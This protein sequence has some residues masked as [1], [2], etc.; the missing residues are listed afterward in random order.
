MMTKGI[1]H[2]RELYKA[3]TVH[4]VMSELLDTIEAENEKY[5][6]FITIDREKVLRRAKELDKKS[7]DR[8]ELFG[9]P[10]AVKDNIAVKDMRLTCASRILD[11]YVS[12]YSA[13]VV[14]RML[15]E[16]AIIIGKTNLDEFA[17]GSSTEYSAFSP[18]RNP[19]APDYVPGGSSGGSAAAVAAGLAPLALGSDTGGSVRQPGSFTGT[20]ALKPTY[21]N[22]SRYGLVAFASSLDVI[23]PMASNLEDAELLYSVISGED[24][25]DSTSAS[26][27]RPAVDLDDCV[28]GVLDEKWLE[29]INP[30]ILKEYRSLIQRLSAGGF[31]IRIVTTELW[32]YA[33][34]AY[35]IITSSEASS[36]LARYDGVRYG[37]RRNE[38]NLLD[39]Y[40]S[41]R[42]QGFGDEVKRRIFLGTFALSAGY[43]DKYYKKAN[44]LREMLKR[45]FRENF[46]GVDFILTPTAPELPFKLGEK[47]NP[48]DMYMS[49]WF[50]APA[51]LAGV[52]AISIPW[53]R[54]TQ[55]LT[56][57][58]Q[59][60]GQTG[61]EEN[62]FILSK[63]LNKI[64]SHF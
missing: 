58:I 3:R 28:I 37:A 8:G 17:M 25:C 36:N 7:G 9:I 11:D 14:E 30:V 53:Y 59:C 44:V 15:A 52:P 32:K 47:V 48:I 38:D 27:K 21:G 60:I 13:T 54:D 10:V 24:R 45:E 5:N 42:T 31:K 50:T 63:K 46:L 2:F 33:L 64:I 41:T 61:D 35:Y 1:D 4:D 55:N 16:D 39:T 20:V 34:N 49:D 23:G 40:Y 22:V 62:I 29:S 26:H 43:Y 6:V 51:S 57:G 12:P 56:V 18:T 19:L